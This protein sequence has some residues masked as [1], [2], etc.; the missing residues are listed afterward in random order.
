[1]TKM[2]EENILG[3]LVTLRPA[4]EKD[5]RMIYEWMAHSDITPRIMGPPAYPDHPIPTWEEFCND[6]KVYFFDDSSPE[7]GRCFVIM[8]SGEAIGQINYNK[9]DKCNRRTA[10]DIWMRSEADCGKGFGTDAL[11]TLCEYLSRKF[12]ITEFFTTPSARNLRAIRAYEKAGF[13]K[14][15]LPTEEAEAKYGPKDYVDSVYMVKRMT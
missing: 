9:I 7:L 8:V 14:V 1:M 13:Q 2:N 10:L 4:T 6:Y 3:N 15:D 11:K 5:R 12:G